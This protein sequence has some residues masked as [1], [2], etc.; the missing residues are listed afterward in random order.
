[1]QANKAVPVGDIDQET[2]PER[3]A[4]RIED[5]GGVWEWTLLIEPDGR[6]DRT[7][8]VYWLQL[9]TLCADIRSAPDQNCHAAFA[10]ILSSRDEIFHWSPRWAYGLEEGAPPDEGYLR[11]E[12]AILREDGV[13]AA[14]VEHWRRLAIPGDDDFACWLTD[15][16]DHP[17]GLLLRLGRFAFCAHEQDGAAEE[18][19]FRLFTRGEDGWSVCASTPGHDLTGVTLTWPEVLRIC[20]VEY[21]E[22]ES[23]AGSAGSGRRHLKIEECI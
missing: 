3:R 15:G 6:V 13:H 20:G 11:W 1:M 7:S 16:S 2:A 5:L 12:G 19:E 10:G 17:K 9:G 23:S 18:T 8:E 22:T 14:Y 21:A 4:P